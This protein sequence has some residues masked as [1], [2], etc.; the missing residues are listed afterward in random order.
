M[1]EESVGIL[2]RRL[3]FHLSADAGLR[4]TL[5]ELL[6]RD[7]QFWETFDRFEYLLGLVHVDLQKQAKSNAWGPIGQFSG[8]RGADHPMIAL[9]VQDEARSAGE[10]WKPLQAGLCGG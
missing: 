3:S 6:P 8:N 1:D 9:A 10:N 2:G 7:E 4:D 5:R